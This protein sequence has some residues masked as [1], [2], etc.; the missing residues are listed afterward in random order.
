MRPIVHLCDD[1]ASALHLRHRLRSH[2][3]NSS[4]SSSSTWA[5]FLPRSGVMSQLWHSAATRRRCKHYVA[6]MGP[7]SRPVQRISGR[8]QL[9]FSPEETRCLQ[10]ILHAGNAIVGDDRTQLLVLQAHV[11]HLKIGFLFLKNPRRCPWLRSWT[12]CFSYS[13]A[14]HHWFHHIILTSC[15]KI[16]DHNL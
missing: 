8:I 1:G 7:V 16:S 10:L 5:G 4:P 3:F 6:P 2:T 13:A 14:S 15:S 12:T 9:Y 11:T